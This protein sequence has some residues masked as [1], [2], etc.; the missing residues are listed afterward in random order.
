M[1]GNLLNPK[2]FAVLAILIFSSSFS[3][4]K[5]NSHLF[6]S[7]NNSKKDVL[8]LFQSTDKEKPTAPTELK[9]SENTGT[10]LTLSWKASTDNV[11]VTS[12]DIYAGSFFAG[13]SKSTSF[14]IKGLASNTWYS[15]KVVAKDAAGNV[16]AETGIGTKTLDITPPT[17]PTA[18]TSTQVTRTSVS[19]SWTGSTDN[20]RVVAYDIF[21]GGNLLVGTS[22]ITRFT[23]TG[24]ASDN[25]Y[26]FSVRARDADGNYSEKSIAL[27]VETLDGKPPTVPTGI[28]ADEITSTSIKLSWNPSID[29]NSVTG[30]QVYRHGTLLGTTTSTS[31]IAS[32][33]IPNNAY[34][35][36]IKAKD[37]NSNFS[38]E[39]EIFT[40]NTIPTPPDYCVSKGFSTVL[41]ITLSRVQLGTIDS[42]QNP[43]QLSTELK[44]GETY[45]ITVSGS[46]YLTGQTQF[47]QRYAVWID[48][49][50]DLDFYDSGERVWNNEVTNLTPVIGTFTVPETAIIGATRIRITS[51][52]DGVG[53]PSPCGDYTGTYNYGRTEDYTVNIVNSTKD[54]NPS[55]A[56]FNLTASET[57]WTTTN[58]SWSPPANTPNIIGYEIY[59]ESTLIGSSETNS[60]SVTGL[61]QVTGY[62]F[63]VKAKKADGILSAASNPLLVKTIRAPWP[64]R[65]TN[66]Q[67]LK[68]TSTKADLAWTPSQNTSGL[69][70]TYY[71]YGSYY[72]NNNTLLGKT[73]N[74]FI[75]ILFSNSYYDDVNVVAIDEMGNDS[76][77]SNKISIKAAQANP[78]PLPPTDLTA[79]EITTS[80]VKLTWTASKTDPPVSSY[81]IY[82]NSIL[83][84][85]VNNGETTF[86]V[87][88]LDANTEYNFIV[89][90]NVEDS[91]QSSTE[92]IL[93]KTASLPGYCKPEISKTKRDQIIS[94]DLG[95][96]VR[97]A[98]ANGYTNDS[99]YITSFTPGQESTI[100]M[101]IDR[102]PNNSPKNMSN[103][104]AV[105]IDFNGDKDFDDAGELVWSGLYTNPSSLDFTAIAKFMLPTTVT[106]GKTGLRIAMK[107]NGIPTP[108]EQF[109]YGEIRDFTVD[110]KK[111]IIEFEA[112]SVPVNLSVSNITKTS[113]IL[114][115]NESTDNIAVTGYDIYQGSLLIGST[116][117]TTFTVNGLS[118]ENT[119]SFTL[120]AKDY[121]KNTSAS[122]EPISFTTSNLSIDEHDSK[123][124]QYILY[125]NPAD[126][127]LFVQ[128]PNNTEFLYKISNMNGQILLQG[129]L[130]QNSIE[131]SPLSSGIYIIELK[132]EE[133]IIIRKF[134]KK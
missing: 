79:T 125:P 18:L 37:A 83:I 106:T 86:K 75:T 14:T 59:Q 91:Y 13:N 89:Y 93:T 12:Y 15:F 40:V 34:S 128:Q 71:I 103:G 8:G 72:R 108:C 22:T 133:K 127:R 46:E 122:S 121:A 84:G 16:S 24:L 92:K 49:N 120:K 4:E 129:N 95:S 78:A 38:A 63:T 19:L 10:S 88:D 102:Y 7:E 39:S 64:G 100:I 57:T 77:S 116:N 67:A 32:N 114:S 31:F 81:Y 107:E 110:I 99:S 36:T 68:I 6:L 29:N 48:Y 55:T 9:V 115:W 26:A 65:P 74:P 90:T 21:Q 28:S 104:L 53:I 97:S 1:K 11:G 96:L 132:N 112:P 66:L 73:K 62:V 119:Y 123:V 54:S 61:K 94:F 101:A 2:L 43:T 130:S 85:K 42:K 51:Q 23:V 41:G 111:P 35:F 47:G 70:L 69:D 117:L 126:H 105:W 82:K 118:A 131:V 109:A 124:N 76:G 30:Y 60:F 27:I 113:A 56:P 33:L 98:P 58:L 45:A 17:R 87:T 25:T 50:G 5:M 134:I 80:S 52:G 3:K 20:E 44:K